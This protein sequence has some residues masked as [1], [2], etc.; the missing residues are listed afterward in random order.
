[1]ARQI[2]LRSNKMR[3]L[4]RI[5][6]GWRLYR[7]HQIRAQEGHVCAWIWSDQ[8]S[9]WSGN[10]DVGGIGNHFRKNLKQKAALFRGS[11]TLWNWAPIAPQN[12]VF[13][14]PVISTI[15]LS[16]K[17]WWI[18]FLS[19]KNKIVDITNKTLPKQR[20]KIQVYSCDSISCLRI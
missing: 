9:S 7:D 6:C 20:P 19:S 13:L 14:T 3:P 10:L 5:E 18:N 1:M 17:S 12:Q 11:R 4:S 16:S 2:R 8:W 15:L